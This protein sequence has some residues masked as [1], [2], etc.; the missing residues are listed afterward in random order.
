MKW[1]LVLE[2]GASRTYF[3]CGV[4]DGFL[5]KSLY[6]DY[7]IGVSAGISFGVSYVSGQ[8]KRNYN[9]M[10]KY[11]NDSRYMGIRHLI[12]RK[13]RSYYNLDF[14]F[15]EIPNKLLPFD[16]NVFD[17]RNTMC[18]AVITRLDNGCPEYMEMP[19]DSSFQLL[20]ATC[21]LPLLFK[22]IEINGVKYMDGGV[23]DSIP[24]KKAYADGC[25]KV[26]AILTHP[27]GYKKEYE[28]ATPL[29]KAAY[30]KYPKFVESFLSRPGKYNQALSELEQLR[31][32][33]KALILAPKDTYGVGRTE[34]SPQKLEKLYNEGYNCFK[35]NEAAIKA[36]I[37]SQHQGFDY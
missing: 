33:G 29:V 24:F 13:N 31:G 34:R 20:R 18:K 4:L 15:D 36:F 6:A 19:R 9:I 32:E 37:N 14:V 12:N 3:T 17:N 7:M 26:I 5:E 28:S 35:E 25:D 23:S 1:G 8:F 2:G 10:T 21:A 30:R 27:Q 22:P 16:F 11:Q